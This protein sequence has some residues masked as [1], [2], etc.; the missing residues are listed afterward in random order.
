MR[1]YGATPTAGMFE[2]AEYYFWGDPAGPQQSDVFV[3]GNCRDEY[4]I[5]ITDGAPNLDL[6]PS[7]S[8]TPI[9]P[10]KPGNCPY[11]LPEQYAAELYRAAAE[12]TPS[13]RSS[14]ASR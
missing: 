6:R 8:Q 9:D 1:P 2:D 14:S 12:T 10:K 7:C 13:R 3:Q 5:H 11:K 4:I